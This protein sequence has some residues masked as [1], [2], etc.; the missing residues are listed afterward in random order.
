[1]KIYI[2]TTADPKNALIVGQYDNQGASMP[3]LFYGDV[4]PLQ[5]MFTDC[6][7]YTSDAA[8]E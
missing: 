8:A 7:L 1:M 6:L 5:V 4:L 3:T 2:D